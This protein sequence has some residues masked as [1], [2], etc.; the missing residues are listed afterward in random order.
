MFKKFPDFRQFMN[1]I[2]NNPIIK[3]SFLNKAG[4]G[5]PFRILIISGIFLFVAGSTWFYF[6]FYSSKNID[7]SYSIAL[8][9]MSKTP[10]G[11]KSDVMQEKVSR[12][13]T[14]KA[15]DEAKN[16]NKSYVPP[17]SSGIANTGRASIVPDA[18][19]PDMKVIKQEN[20][21]ETSNV[22]Y[23][24]KMQVPAPV[25]IPKIQDPTDFPTIHQKSG[26]QTAS[27]TIPINNIDPE[28]QKAAMDLVASW[29]GGSSPQTQIIISPD[30]PQQTAYQSEPIKNYSKEEKPFS[31]TRDG[32]QDKGTIL[33][34][35]GRGIYAHT[36]ISV[37]SDT[38]GQIILEADSGPVAG[39]RM[40]GNFSNAGGNADRLIV[41]VT[42]I[43][44]NGEEISANGIVIAP[45]SMETSVASSVD[46]HY[47]SRFILP[48]AAAFVQGLG[49]AIQTTSDT[50]GNVSPFGGYTYTQNLNIGK[51]LGI[52]AG[53]AAQQVA[54][55]LQQN[56]PTR[57]TVHLA[58]NSSVGVI[59]TTNILSKHNMP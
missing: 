16:D 44:H 2:N 8:P 40:F 51:Q 26:F 24:T 59:F 53:T 31:T 15:A 41:Q 18:I 30:Q 50:V 46:Q 9:D 47:V 42:K 28:R 43:I 21:N 6:H 25:K 14:Q 20:N 34:P 13:A 27:A 5:G 48:A 57:P 11:T 55:A 33:I 4:S 12:I 58:A 52:A 39:D 54:N 3:K 22:S 45:D 23:Q 36:I 1:S 38:S 10:G 32:F 35:A 49:S 7:I 37:D 56:A 29:N 17:I 19:I